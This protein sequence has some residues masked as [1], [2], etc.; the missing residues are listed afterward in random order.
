MTLPQVSQKVSDAQALTNTVRNPK[1]SPG[2]LLGLC[3]IATLNPREVS[4]VPDSL[5]FDDYGHILKMWV[6]SI[7]TTCPHKRGRAP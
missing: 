4:N 1:N 2:H 6:I 5:F 7:S 3:S